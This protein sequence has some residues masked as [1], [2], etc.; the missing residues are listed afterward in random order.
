VKKVRQGR[1]MKEARQ[2]RAMKWRG[3]AAR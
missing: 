1:A 3:R 2:G